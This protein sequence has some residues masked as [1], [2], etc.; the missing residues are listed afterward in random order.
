MSESNPTPPAPPNPPGRGFLGWLG[1]QV[2]HITKAMKT[3][4]GGPKTIYRDRTVEEKTLPTDPNVK[5]RRT[6]I[7]EVV[8]DPPGRLGEAKAGE[9]EKK[10]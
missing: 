3:D 9:A 1:R 10:S 6:V 2:G 8:V 4:V 7:D 5:L